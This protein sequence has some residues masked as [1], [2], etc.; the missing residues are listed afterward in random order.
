[1]A[2]TPRV[3]VLLIVLCPAVLGAQPRPK[4]GPTRA[5]LARP[6]TPAFE[7]RWL[8]PYLLTGQVAAARRALM[9]RNPAEAVKELRRHLARKDAAFRPQARYLLAHALLRIK[10]YQRAARLFSA[11]E[12]QYPL[13]ADYHRYHEARARHRLKQYAAAARLA[14]R[15]T[16][17][18]A[19]ATDAALLQADALRAQRRWKE[20][21]VLWQAYVDA[22]K[23]KRRLGEIHF[24]LGQAREKEAAAEAD[25]GKKAQLWKRAHGH[26]KKVLVIS[27]MS[28]HVATARRR[29]TALSARGAG[30]AE[31][32]PWEA[33]GQAS[34]FFRRMR[35]SLSERAYAALLKRKGVGPK[36]RCQAA[37]RM[38]KSVYKQR[39]RARAEPM[40]RA[41]EQQCRKAGLEDLVV[42]SIF[43]GAR[44]LSRA[45]KFRKAV[46]QY[47]RLEKE[48]SRHTYADDARLRMAEVYM[49]MGKK[50]AARKT[51]AAIPR[52]YPD[53][54]MKREAL[55]RL[56]RQAYIARRYKRAQKHLDRIIRKLGRATIYYAHGRA[57]YWK[58]RIMDTRRRGAT[59]R[60]LYA[61]CIQEYPLSYYALQSFN[62]LREKHPAQFAALVIKHLDPTGVKPG[63]WSFSARALF[64]APAFLRGV[65][66][67]RLG[68]GD[69]AARELARAGIRIKKGGRPADLWLAAVL[70]DRAG[71]WRHS[72]Q[73]PRSKDTGYRYTYP[74]GDNF[75]RWIISYPRAFWPLVQANARSAGVPWQLVLAVMREESGFSPT[76]ESYANAM[77]LMQLIL[78]TAKAAGKRFKLKVT[79]K[80]LNDPALNIKLGSAY[81][82]S[83]R[84]YFSGVLPLTIAGYNAGGGAPTKWL[85]RFGK[86]PLDEYL[87][88]V[89]YDQTRRY[90][91]RVL[92]SLFI[93][94]VLYEKGAARIPKIPQKLPKLKRK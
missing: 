5:D 54:D 58:A 82:G 83:L 93:Y 18:S 78:P 89:P 15:V 31:L 49:E 70:Y 72:H 61:R 44:G 68:F 75:R 59:A 42:K 9:A 92:S 1:M 81:L 77:G 36:L 4:Y 29:V 27:P 38:A 40:F 46:A 73:V 28:R 19:L 62:R 26:Y 37:Y 13:L 64:G 52:K 74:H 33:Y 7:Q 67:A 43:N 76:V 94:S 17:G 2:S 14:A 23:G 3:Y 34:V 85:R 60:K 56:A 35:N 12:R 11:L 63:T 20:A 88:R 84:R 39:Q 16:S 21:A 65:E 32:S 53:G 6:A 48:F 10:K 25:A 30:K 86:I 87:E 91:K 50:G 41:A 79:R 66:L 80:R 57:L 55:W 24:R 22:G 51:L 71:I 90:T 69:A 47:R 45:G 8:T